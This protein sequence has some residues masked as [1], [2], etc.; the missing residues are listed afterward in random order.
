M[1]GNSSSREAGSVFCSFEATSKT[2]KPSLG[3]I[4]DCRLWRAQR[5]VQIPDNGTGRRI[6]WDSRRQGINPD[7]PIS[8]ESVRTAVGEAG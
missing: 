3:G 4:D 7:Q 6:L 5:L 1:A 8:N 2:E